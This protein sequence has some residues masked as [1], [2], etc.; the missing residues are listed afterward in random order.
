[1]V[2]RDNRLENFERGTSYAID[3]AVYASSKL[4]GERDARTRHRCRSLNRVHDDRTGTGPTHLTGSEFCRL[5]VG[6]NFNASL[7]EDD[8]GRTVS[9]NRGWGSSSLE[10]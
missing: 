5:L 10:A 2:G 1:M 6:K 3:D 7:L 8:M 4:K 9:P